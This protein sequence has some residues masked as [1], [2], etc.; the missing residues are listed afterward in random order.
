NSDGTLAAAQDLVV[1]TPGPI[2]AGDLTGDGIPDL[3]VV[4]GSVNYQG[5]T[6]F[7]GLGD[8]SFDNRILTPTMNQPTAVAIGDFNGDGKKDL[9]VTTG[10]VGGSLV[11]VLINTGNGIFAAPTPYS[12]G[13]DPKWVIADDFNNDAKLDLA[14]ANGAGV[15]ILLGNGNGTFGAPATI[16]AGGA[17]TYLAAGDLNGG[18]KKGR[19]V[20]K[21]PSETVRV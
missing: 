4:T 2:A 5:V 15:S 20:G 21:R 11:N 13:S 3:A 6:I 7:P 8:G 1:K 18:R 17:A 9:A 12:V 19:G 16:A 10:S 14:V